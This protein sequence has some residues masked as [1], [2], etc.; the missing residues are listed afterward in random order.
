MPEPT[1]SPDLQHEAAT[2]AAVSKTV[3]G[4]ATHSFA[5]SYNPVFGQ[6]NPLMHLGSKR[7]LE[8]S[9][10]GTLPRGEYFN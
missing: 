7:A 9:D 8:A 5:T 1:A 6:I 10:L 2:T 3:E 4:I